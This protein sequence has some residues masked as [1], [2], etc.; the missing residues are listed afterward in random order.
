[1]MSIN[2]REQS[3]LIARCL[4][5]FDCVLASA[6]LALLVYWYRV[7]WSPYYTRLVILIFVLCFITFQSFQLYRSWRG[8]KYFRELFVILKAWGA[9]VGFLLFYF[10]IFKISVAYSRVVILIWSIS[11]PFIL[12]A[13]HVAF[14]KILRAAR[15][16]GK[17]VRR[18]VIV[19]AGDL[20]VTLLKQVETMPWAGIEVIGFFD[21][22]IDD[23]EIT[24]VKGK[25]ILGN[26]AAIAAYLELHAIDYVYIALPMRAERKIFRILREC[27]SLGARIYLVPDLYVYGLHHAEIQSLGDLLILNFNPNTEWKRSFDLVFSIAVLILTLPLTLLVALAIKLSD[28]GP[29]FYRHRRITSA[30]KSFECLKFRTMRVGAEAELEKL[31][32]ENAELRQEWEHSFKLKNDPRVTRIGRF[33][34]RTS[35]DEFPQFLNVIRG[36]MSVVGARPIVGK[37]LNEFYKDSAGRYCSMK[38]GI[39]GPWQVG[40]RSDIEEYEE[41]VRL[42]DW[43]ILNFS[44]WTD[45]KIIA[46]TVLRMFKSNGA[47]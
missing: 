22:K 33:L 23:Q 35:L 9:V 20:G 2:L 44:L 28:G 42:D 12:F 1:M 8:W 36:D 15:Q 13:I 19:G 43:Y 24:E 4:H 3:S 40:R 29:I 47:Y 37:E 14:R 17:N 11:T 16:N 45:I 41:R 27:R 30:G 10:F 21:D 32:R 39:T 6:Y 7:P 5:L 26:T 34:R 38:P 25:P 18:A 31:L 46:K